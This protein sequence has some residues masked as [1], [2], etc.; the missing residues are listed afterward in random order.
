MFETFYPDNQD[1]AD[2][3]GRTY[4]ILKK[5]KLCFSAIFSLLVLQALRNL[6]LAKQQTVIRDQEVIRTQIAKDTA[7]AS[8]MG[9]EEDPAVA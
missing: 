7:I 8:M 6:F 9:E 4:F 3:S 5:Y 1:L 2:M